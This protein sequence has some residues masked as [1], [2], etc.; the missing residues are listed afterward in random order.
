MFLYLSKKISIPN[1][2][3]L[4]SLA[5]D[6]AAGWIACGGEN[7]VLKVL[8]LQDAIVAPSA[9]A[10][11]PPVGTGTGITPAS[12]P[13][14]LSLSQTLEGHSGVVSRVAWNDKHTKL[15]T[16]DAN[17]M[18]I[19]WV[20][21]KGM[22]YEEMVN[23]RAKCTVADLAWSARGDKIAIAYVDGSIILG[24]VEGNRI[25]GKDLGFTLARVAWA[26][27]ANF[28]LFAGQDGSARLYDVQGNYLHKM[29]L[30]AGDDAKIVDMHWHS[31]L[32]GTGNGAEPALAIAF[33][34]GKLQMN[35][36]ERDTQPVL[37]DTQMTQLVLRWS[38]SG[39][40]LAVAGHQL[41][42]K[43]SAATGAADGSEPKPMVVVQ[44]YSRS[45]EYLR[46]L[47]VPQG[48]VI[49]AITWDATGLR[50]ALAVDAAIYFCNVHPE[51]RAAGMR[52]AV[53]WAMDASPAGNDGGGSDAESFSRVVFADVKSGGGHRRELKMSG[54]VQIVVP[55]GKDHVG[56]VVRRQAA[57]AVPAAAATGPSAPAA[58]SYEHL[59]HVMNAV[60]TPL[61]V[62]SLAWLVPTTACMSGTYL[63]VSDG[64][65]VAYF[66]Y[67]ATSSA[68]ALSA[69]LWARESA[70]KVFRADAAPSSSSGPNGNPEVLP[71]LVG[72]PPA[73]TTEATDLVVS[74]ACN[75]D[76]L[77]VAKASGALIK[78]AF[79]TM[80]RV[81]AAAFAIRPYRIQCNLDATLLSVVDLTGILRLVSFDAT[82]SSSSS[83]IGLPST[84]GGSMDSKAGGNGG[85]R[86]L[87]ME[88]RDVWAV[89]WSDD[90]RDMYVVLEK[91]R[92][93]VMRNTSPEEPLTATGLAVRF[94]DLEVTLVDLDHLISG[95]PPISTTTT[96]GATAGRLTNLTEDGED[97][98]IRTIPTRALRDTQMILAQVGIPDATSFAESHPHPRLWRTIAR[99]ALAA[100]DW[101]SAASCFARVLDYASL[102][103]LKGVQAQSGDPE[104]Q[105][106]AVLAYL[107]DIA[108][109]EHQYAEID[110]RDLAVALRRSIGDAARVV[111]IGKAGG[112]DDAVIEQCWSAM[113]RDAMARRSWAQAATYFAQA[114]DY[115]ALAECHLAAHDV[116]ALEALARALP[117]TATATLDRIGD[118][119]ARLGMAREATYAF[120]KRGASAKGMA[121]CLALNQWDMAV[122]LASQASDNGGG[123][124]GAVLGVDESFAR[125]ET[126]LKL[127]GDGAQLAALYRSANQHLK[128]ARVLLDAATAASRDRQE[129]VLVK[130][131][132]VMGALQVERYHRQFANT[133]PT[134]AAI[135]GNTGGAS[136]LGGAGGL[137]LAEDHDSAVKAGGDAR[138]LENPWRGAEA[139]HFYLLAQ[140]QFYTG[141]SDSALRTAM[142]L[143]SYC[144]ILSAKTVYSLIALLSH[145]SRNY[146]VCSRALGKLQSLSED[147]DEYK[148]YEQMAINI[149]TNHPVTDFSNRVQI[150]CSNCSEL[151]LELDNTCAGCD[152]TYLTCI[153]S[154]RLIAD[155]QQAFACADCKHRA[156]DSE[157]ASFNHCPLCHAAL[158]S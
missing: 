136:K 82:G 68:S 35:C 93:Y 8:K 157:I 85:A 49:R 113:G 22:W 60:G 121:V 17:G 103:W 54:T 24:G 108:Q 114:R 89:Q 11:A 20:L 125:M 123:N 27:D 86:L 14:N 2:T 64:T 96:N 81:A 19:V 66:P 13:A 153:A 127:R 149:F 42:A 50:L 53:C 47:K 5:W 107:G 143:R 48:K 150:P 109:A 151:M 147:D 115:D 142:S 95:A 97:T 124:G 100:S 102:Q 15:T 25:L 7:A 130:K 31:N 21:Y 32:R 73:N 111:Q 156:L 36:H 59:A 70:A 79:P 84:A 129:P 152:T 10:N 101:A 45:G 145:K 55:G 71:L 75:D 56:I 52:D 72:T 69:M 62:R 46:Y 155:P 67:Q 138:V 80:A 132:F 92:M 104:K 34:N 58:S 33:D 6:N 91:S 148:T 112:A 74:M 39:S 26:P 99:S 128:S 122:E 131:L 38:P 140:R 41:L 78:Y 144:D 16:A 106:A 23:D 139:Y 65:H 90:H 133:S 117:V 76:V 110:R 87:E 61:D 120:S 154:G 83:N 12:A 37:V 18:I 146:Q 3:A 88:R 29:Q 1:D 28:L 63:V 119:L 30:F 9:A 158:M 126:Q 137:M 105:R 44:L 141:D 116:A 4:H 134:A 135:A 40:H 118:G 51:Y 77:I 94:A 57:V 98:V 43:P